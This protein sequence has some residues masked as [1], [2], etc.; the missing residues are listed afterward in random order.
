MLTLADAR[1]VVDGVLAAGAERDWPPLAAAVVDPTGEVQALARA[2]GG[3]PMTSRI[4]VG[5]A[6]TV[7]VSGMPSGDSEQ[8]PDGIVSAVRVLYG[9]DYVSRAG[10]LPIVRDGLVVGAVGVSGAT[11]DQDEEAATLALTEVFGPSS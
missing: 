11:S 2:D 3:R 7:L 6:R 9:G 10:G 8:L 4:A 5:K 1:A